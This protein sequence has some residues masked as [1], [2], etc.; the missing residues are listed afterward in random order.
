MKFGTKPKRKILPPSRALL[1]EKDGR[2]YA[3]TWCLDE[4]GWRC[5]YSSGLRWLRGLSPE[6][7]RHELI[8]RKFTFHWIPPD[9]GKPIPPP[10]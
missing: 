6:Q 10:F 5:W 8:A 3:L 9:I 4:N 7:A 1:A 2:R